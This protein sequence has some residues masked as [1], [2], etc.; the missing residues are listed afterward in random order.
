[1]V[2]VNKQKIYHFPYGVIIRKV[3]RHYYIDL[4]TNEFT[5]SYSKKNVIENSALHHMGL[6]FKDEHVPVIEEVEPLGVDKSEYHFKPKTGFEKF[7]VDQF[8][9]Q[10]TKLNKI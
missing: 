10:S 6:S 3:L 2:K 5:L 8:K 1:M 7:V 4:I 9:R